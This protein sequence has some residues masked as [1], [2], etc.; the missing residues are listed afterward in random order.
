MHTVDPI[1]P[2]PEPLPPVIEAA[3]LPAERRTDEDV[4]D[5]LD[6]VLLAVATV[7]SFLIVGTI[8][9]ALFMVA[10]GFRN[11]NSKALEDALTK[12]A[13]FV[14]P[15]QLVIYMAIL[16]F[17]ALLVRVRHSTPLLPAIRW[18]TP[19]RRR[20]WNAV[21]IGAAL[22]LFSDI[23]QIVLD[24]W[25]PKS[26]PITEYFRDRPSA[27]LLGG[28]GILVAPFMEEVVFRGFIYP[29]LARWTGT[30]VSVLVTAGAFTALHGQ[31]LGYSWAPLLLIFIVGAVLTVTRV[32]TRSVATCVIVHMTYNFAL[33]AQTYIATHGFRQ[34]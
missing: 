12:N 34:M 22:A 33:L 25:I 30:L 26:L 21:M 1:S 32:V 18:N 17:M 23:G 10:H 31:Q 20:G 27:L 3:S 28:F 13:F 5:L 16:G 19:A 9:T 14:V 4:I 11:L 7:G 29:A 2:L 15:T 6:V 8:A 24:R